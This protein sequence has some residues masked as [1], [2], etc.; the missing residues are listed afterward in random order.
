MLNISTIAATLNLVLVGA[1]AA[2]LI[3]AAISDARSFTISNRLCLAVAALAPLYIITRVAMPGQEFLGGSVKLHLLA[4]V[5][6]TIAVFAVSSVFFA[7]G[8]MGGGDV[9]L[10]T[11]VSLWT[12]PQWTLAFLFITALAGGVVTLAVLARAY[13][14]RRFSPETSQIVKNSDSILRKTQVPY[15]LGIAVGGLFAAT[16]IGHAALMSF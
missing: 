9:K 5:G 15:G 1:L 13:I 12:G 4:T 14:K 11:A 8:L 2:L 7:T 16:K 3:R 10:M 6:I